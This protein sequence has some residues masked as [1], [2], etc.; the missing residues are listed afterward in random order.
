MQINVLKEN[1]R[2]METIMYEKDE[3]LK[4]LEKTNKEY[5][6][7]NILYKEAHS[8]N[9]FLKQKHEKDNKKLTLKIEDIQNTLEESNK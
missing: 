4:K 5:D 8:E 1:L 2:S 7:I 9:E 3:K 6:K